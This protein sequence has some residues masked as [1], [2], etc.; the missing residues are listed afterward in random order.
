MELKA[1]LHIHTREDV[2]DG[3]A[4]DYSIYGL[5]DKAKDLKFD[6]IALT[7]HLKFIYKEEYGRYAK[8]RGIILIPGIELSLHKFMRENHVVVLNCSRDAEKVD[9]FETLRQYKKDNPEIFVI[10]VHPDFGFLESIGI[11]NLEK[12]IALFDAIEH[13]WFYSKRIDFNRKAEQIAKKYCK[14]FIATA[15]MHTLEYMDADYLIAD[16]ESKTLESFF[17]A[18]KNKKIRNVTRPKTFFQML[19]FYLVLSFKIFI[20]K[21][22]RRRNKPSRTGLEH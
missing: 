22:A 14:P 12:Q 11:P 2:V 3:A 10:A 5:I 15:D 21:A 13:S 20:A 9:S 4:I 8:E 6:V 1:S 7:G 19:G 17:L 18:I 16:A